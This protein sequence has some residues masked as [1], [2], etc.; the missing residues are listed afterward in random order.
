LSNNN[1]SAT[2]PFFKKIDELNKT[3]IHTG[4]FCKTFMAKKK[5]SSI[6]DVW[7]LK[8]TSLYLT[9]LAR[10]TLSLPR[11]SSHF[12]ALV[13]CSVRCLWQ[14]E[15]QLHPRRLVSQNHLSLPHLASAENPK[16]AQAIKPF[17]RSRGRS[18]ISAA[19]V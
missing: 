15:E 7:F 12:G 14:K 8:I 1:K 13:V 6:Q 11:P 3:Y 2:V 16:L 4:L 9:L 10:R 19:Q 18:Q 5:S 17:W